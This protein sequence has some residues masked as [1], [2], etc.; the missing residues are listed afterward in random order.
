ML[1]SCVFHAVGDKIRLPHH[2]SLPSYPRPCVRATA[3]AH[4]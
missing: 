3:Q 1:S 4:A 2:Y